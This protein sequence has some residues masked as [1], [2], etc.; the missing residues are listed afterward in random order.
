MFLS[1]FRE[2]FCEDAFPEICQPIFLP[3]GTVG[4]QPE[5]DFCFSS[6]TANTLCTVPIGANFSQEVEW[7]LEN[8]NSTQCTR[9]RN[10]AQEES[11][12]WLL[13]FYYCNASWALAITAMVCT[14][15][16]I[17]VILSSL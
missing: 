13:A 7:C 3:N 9:I 10:E 14:N 16:A 6:P 5:A 12:N 17:L 15:R 1:W 4:G 8:Y 2:L 11:T